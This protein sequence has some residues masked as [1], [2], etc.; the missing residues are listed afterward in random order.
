MVA[1]PLPQ[2]STRFNLNTTSQLTAEGANVEGLT[3]PPATAAV[4][5]A[6]LPTEPGFVPPTPLWYV[7][8][9]ANIPAGPVTDR[10][11]QIFWRSNVG[12][13]PKG[14]M[15]PP[16]P[17]LAPG[18]LDPINAALQQSSGARGIDSAGI[19]GHRV[20]VGTAAGGTT[21][22]AILYGSRVNL[23]FSHYMV[24]TVRTPLAPDTNYVVEVVAVGSGGN[25]A[26][27]AALTVRTAPTLV[28]GTGQ[29][30]RAPNDVHLSAPL[31]V[32]QPVTG[33]A[34]STQ[35]TLSFDTVRG[36]DTYEVWDNPT[37]GTTV[38]MDP[39]APGL[40]VGDVKR[41]TTP[42]PITQPATVPSTITVKVNAYTVPGQRFALKA[43]AVR[44]ATAD[45]PK[46]YGP[47]SD[48]VRGTIPPALTAPGA[49]TALT[50]TPAPPV[51]NV[52][53]LSWTAPA[54]TIPN[55]PPEYYQVL[56]GTK[57]VGTVPAGTTTLT[58]PLANGAYSITV[59][60][61]NRQGTGPAS[62]ALAGTLT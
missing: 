37:P 8:G 39:A 27:S 47:F 54:V 25:S 5:A 32:I 11:I 41:T 51:G 55:G 13:I 45:E 26:R 34:G 53:N 36:A 16:A 38:I 14:G 33:V 15:T 21:P 48:V 60:A 52:A 44:N 22:L 7:A 24:G 18:D 58:F 56:S 42:S 10:S 46:F 50:F 40:N 6:A 61:T 30:F 49:P 59:R 1:T 3:L 20:Y 43:R 19:L 12:Q 4:R 57:V 9:S 29:P 62:T 28:F 31:P 2:S 23:R 35:I 17:P